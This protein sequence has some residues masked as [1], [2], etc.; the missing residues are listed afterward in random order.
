[1][2]GLVP[3]VADALV[4]LGV[5]TMTL[6][7]YGAIRM[8]DIYTRLHAASKAVVLGVISFVLASIV[9]G[10][11]G[12]VFRVLLIGVLLLLTTPVAAHTIARAAY[13]GGE[14]MQT[15]GA[16]DEADRPFLAE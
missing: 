16:V 7:V 4:I 13:R 10:E 6:G 1:M 9:T 11:S 12:I 2:S 3:Y 15:P 5:A 14:P 8:P